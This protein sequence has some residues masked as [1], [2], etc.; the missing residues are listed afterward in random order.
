MKKFVTNVL[1]LFIVLTIVLTGCSSELPKK[2]NEST[3][4][5]PIE[6]FNW[7]VKERDKL[8]FNAANEITQK[9]TYTYKENGQPIKIVEPQKMLEYNYGDNG[10]LKTLTYNNLVFDL[11]FSK[12]NGQFVAENRNNNYTDLTSVK[13]VLNEEN[14][15]LSQTFFCNQELLFREE[16]SYYSNGI[17]KTWKYEEDG[18]TYIEQYDNHGNVLEYEFLKNGISNEKMLFEYSDNMIVGSK[19]IVEDGSCV[20]E[21]L[22][23]KENNKTR[24]ATKDQGGRIVCYTEY[25]Y[26]DYKNLIKLSRYT[27]DNILYFQSNRTWE[28]SK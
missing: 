26:D 16:F 24:T 8:Y 5:G 10:Q 18:D 25:Q 4:N 21:T 19:T 14:R 2:E 23:V 6:A 20:L 3:S 7:Y 1:S 28:T 13:I 17:V 11:S 15:L 27:R 12:Q 22:E 9:N